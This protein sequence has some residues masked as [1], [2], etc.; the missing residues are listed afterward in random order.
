MVK[1]AV[2]PYSVHPSVAY[3]QAIIRNLETNTGKDLD[4]WLKVLKAQGP[5]DPKA[6]AAWLKQQG[7]GGTQAGFVAERSKGASGHAFDDTPEG[8]LAL[9]PGYVER[10]YT[11]KKAHL[12][13]LYDTLLELALALGE[14]VK[15]CPCETIVPL[16][17]HHVFAQLKPTTLSRID[18]GL[19][20]GDPAAV[21]E[22][23]GRLID[24]GGFQKKD[25]LTHRIEVKSAADI[26]G[27][28]KDWLR[29]AY[30]RDVK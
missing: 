29:K 9:A 16:Y 2:N 26:D 8:Y 6:R 1:R 19:A 25:R 17:R 14:D 12:R 24:T 20:L 13:P 18:V 7:L 27:F 3:V 5:K 28:L 15:A 21:K 30:A 11:A 23:S 4:G 10:Q 22:P